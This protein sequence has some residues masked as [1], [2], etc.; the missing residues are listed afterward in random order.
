MQFTFCLDSKSIIS[1]LAPLFVS[2][3]FNPSFY[4]QFVTP[5]IPPGRFGEVSW[6]FTKSCGWSPGF[7]TADE[8]ITHQSPLGRRPEDLSLL[9]LSR[10]CLRLLC[11]HKPKMN[12]SLGANTVDLLLSLWGNCESR[13]LNVISVNLPSTLT[14]THWS[15]LPS[16]AILTAPIVKFMMGFGFRSDINHTDKM[17]LENIPATLH[18]Q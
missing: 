1:F 16:S 13:I 18:N 2:L 14:I 4:I 15:G 12:W 17:L 3:F 8:H 9:V 10:I 7:Y 5:L 11:S 6:N